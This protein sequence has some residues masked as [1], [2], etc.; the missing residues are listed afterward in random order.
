MAN[1]YAAGGSAAATI[2]TV[3]GNAGAGEG[4]NQG[5]DVTGYGV[6]TVLRRV[7]LADFDPMITNRAAYCNYAVYLPT[8]AADGGYGVTIALVPMHCGVS[9]GYMELTARNLLG[10]AFEISTLFLLYTDA[11]QVYI[12]PRRAFTE[13]ELRHIRGMLKEQLPGRFSTRFS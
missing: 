2:S 6:G 3:R 10:V 13:E 8:R 5:M 7:N 11:A 1:P 12:V 9:S 4:P